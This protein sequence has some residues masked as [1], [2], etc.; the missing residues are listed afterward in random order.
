[1]DYKYIE[2]LLD[3]YWNCDTTAE[4]ESILC[5]FFSQA[6]V[7]AHLARYRSLFQ[8]EQEQSRLHLSDAFDE[9]V[10]AAVEQATNEPQHMVKTRYITWSNRLRPLYR[11]AATVAI[12]TLLGIA[13][14]HSFSGAEQNPKGWDYNQSAYKDSYEDPQKAY[15]MSMETLELFREGAQTAVNDSAQHQGAAAPATAPTAQPGH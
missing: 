12:V 10:L 14:Q 3:R 7:P 2:Q 15:E 4:E 6:E 13:A 5:S 8:Y 1:M 11:A 9:R